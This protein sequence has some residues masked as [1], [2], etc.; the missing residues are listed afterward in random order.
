MAPQ[1]AKAVKGGTKSSKTS[2]S[3]TKGWLG[4]AET[5]VGN[6]DNWYGESRPSR[7]APTELRRD[8]RVPIPSRS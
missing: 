5:A 4:S 7:R 1:A 2:T 3:T 8:G 6:L